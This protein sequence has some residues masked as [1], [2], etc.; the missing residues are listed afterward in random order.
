[1]PGIKRQSES[2]DNYR[3]KRT[4]VKDAGAVP[5]S[6]GAK[7]NYVPPSFQKRGITKGSRQFNK[8]GKLSKEL[9]KA[10][11]SKISQKQKRDGDD[12]EPEDSD[13]P[14]DSDEEMDSEED[15]D[16]EAEVANIE[17]EYGGQ[18]DATG[19][20]S[21]APVTGKNL[22]SNEAAESGKGTIAHFLYAPMRNT[23][24]DLNLHFQITRLANLT[25]NRRLWLWNA[26]QQSPMLM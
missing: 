4:K 19:H 24:A 22:Q 7:K 13:L 20:Q 16:V 2:G 12:E 15:N 3:G 8:E 21:Q 17:E 6:K 1:M 26:R 11:K 9:A 5:T 18:Q 25:P 23:F 14:E 10:G